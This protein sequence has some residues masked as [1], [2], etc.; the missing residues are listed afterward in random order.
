MGSKL[1]NIKE[2]EKHLP[3]DY[4]LI[5]RIPILERVHENKNAKKKDFKYIEKYQ[6]LT[7]IRFSPRKPI[8]KLLDPNDF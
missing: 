7:Q 5:E 1:K 3:L 6:A 8:S 2:F 4:F